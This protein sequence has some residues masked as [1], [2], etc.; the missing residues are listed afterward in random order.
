MTQSPPTNNWPRCMRNT[1]PNASR[2]SIDARRGVQRSLTRDSY[3][4]LA[5]SMGGD[6]ESHF[7]SAADLI[8]GIL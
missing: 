4:F 5:K 7:V 1:T 3:Q 6:A 2:L 8:R